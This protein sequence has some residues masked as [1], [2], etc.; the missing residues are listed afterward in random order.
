MER[1][2]WERLY[3]ILVRLDNHKFRGV[4]TSA[5]IA[6]VF[7]WGVIHDR[8]VRWACQ[9]KNWPRGLWRGRLPS[10][11]TMSR[12]LKRPEVQALLDAASQQLVG[13]CEDH[14]TCV[15]VVDAK[16]LPVGGH[17]KD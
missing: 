7:F 17:S 14:S 3:A 15:K 8:P 2:R 16:P 4:F 6:A 10:Q 1:E 9:P 5:A 12:R 11:S 13:T